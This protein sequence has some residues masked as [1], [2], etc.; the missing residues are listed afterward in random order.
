MLRHYLLLLLGVFA[1]STAVIQIKA[2]H[3]HP[4]VLAAMRLSIAS[5]LLAPLAWRE[6]Q[7][8]KAVFGWA[9]LRR[10]W[11]PSVVLAVHFIS[12]AYG[13]RMTIVAQAS[14]IVNLAPVAIPFFLHYLVGERINRI[15]V[16][17]TI[18][19]LLGVVLL[20]IRD[21]LAGG[22]DVWG[23][24][25]CFGSML[26]FAWYLALGR[27]NRDFPSLWL[28]VVPV[29]AQ[30]A[31]L[32][33]LA[34]IPWL[35]TFEVSSTREWSLMFG[36]AVLP[37]IMGHSLLNAS[38]RHLRGQVVSLGNVGQ[39]IFAGIMAFFLF[40]Q[41]PPLSFYFASLMVITGVALVVFAA[42]T[43]PPKLR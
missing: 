21:V 8:H 18:L 2:S 10:T 3:T 40:S 17:G 36:L 11:L 32:C 7:R 39:F 1:C 23:N 6:Y 42:P 29:Y 35:G 24:A 16:Y 14:L 26:L 19:A 33:L 28:Y 22:G 30:A 37:T 15:E 31:V 9:Q 38:M 5:V 25:V 12:W 41:T 43:P 4:F 20:S 27:K 13:A 34:A